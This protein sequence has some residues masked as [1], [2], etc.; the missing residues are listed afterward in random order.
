MT[1]KKISQTWLVKFLTFVHVN[2][3]EKKKNESEEEENE[4]LN[5]KEDRE[6]WSLY[7]QHDESSSFCNSCKANFDVLHRKHH[8][9][10]CGYI[11][12][13]Q[14]ISICVWV[15][16]FVLGLN[17]SA[18][19]IEGN[20]VCNLCFSQYLKINSVCNSALMVGN[21]K[22]KEKVY[23]IE[24]SADS[25]VKDDEISSELRDFVSFPK[26]FEVVQEYLLD[27]KVKNFCLERD[28]YAKSGEKNSKF[29]DILQKSDIAMKESASIYEKA[30]HMDLSNRLNQIF[31]G[32]N[33][34][35]NA[36][37]S[38][39]W[40]EILFSLLKRITENFSSRYV[41]FS[42]DVM[43]LIKV[44]CVSGG[45]PDS[46]YLLNGVMF[47][48][49]ICRKVNQSNLKNGRILLVCSPIDYLE[50]LSSQSNV[51]NWNDSVV[52][53]SVMHTERR[54]FLLSLAKKIISLNPS[55]VISS[56]Y[57]CGDIQEVLAKHNIICIQNLKDSNFERISRITGSKVF[58]V[59][60]ILHHV[61]A[62]S[63]LNT[64]LG[65]FKSFQISKVSLLNDSTHTSHVKI[66]MDLEKNRIFPVY[67]IC[68][69]GEKKPELKAIKKI[70][71][72]AFRN[73]VNSFF[74][75]SLMKDKFAYIS[76]KEDLNQYNLNALLVQSSISYVWTRIQKNL[77]KFECFSSRLLCTGPYSSQ[78]SSLGKFL[79]HRF[80][81][82]AKQ[83]WSCRVCRE[84][85]L[86]HLFVC[87]HGKG[88]IYIEMQ[89]LPFQM[90]ENDRSI[91]MW[92]RCNICGE[93]TTPITKMSEFTFNI[94]LSK[95]IQLV[96]EFSDIQ[97]LILSTKCMHCAFSQQTQYFCS[98]NF[99]V[100]FRFEEIN[101]YALES[102]NAKSA[103]IL[104]TC[105]EDFVKFKEISDEFL[106]LFSNKIS[107]ITSNNHSDLNDLD[108]EIQDSNEF[109]PALNQIQVYRAFRDKIARLIASFEAQSITPD[110]ESFPSICEKL[111]EFLC[112]VNNFH[113]FSSYSWDVPN[114]YETLKT[115]PI[116][117]SSPSSFL[118]HVLSTEEYIRFLYS[119]SFSEVVK[120]YISLEELFSGNS[121]DETL[122]NDSL[123][124]LGSS[125]DDHFQYDFKNSA[126]PFLKKSA[127]KV[128]FARQFHVLRSLYC[129]SNF[130][131][132]NSIWNSQDWKTTGGKSN[133][134]FRKT[135]DEKFV[136]KFISERE[137]SMFKE[138]AP[139]YFRHMISSKLDG[140]SS[141]LIP[142]LGMF[143]YV[144]SEQI[145]NADFTANPCV[146][147]VVMPNLFAG[148]NLNQVF[149]LKGKKTGRF[150]LPNS[151]SDSSSVLLDK[152]FIFYSKGM[153]LP[154]K[155]KSR[156]WLKEALERD[157]EFLSA[158]DIMDYSLLVG[159]KDQAEK[160]I[161]IGIIDYLHK[162]TLDKKLENQFKSMF[163]KEDPTVVHP[164]K[165]RK[166]FLDAMKAYFLF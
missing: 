138:T 80:F 68:L 37:N 8:C 161:L 166:R 4:E 90:I 57:I 98:Q 75:L 19:I 85:I 50:S 16:I 164:E 54:D 83:G 82:P 33:A 23:Y 29:K 153:P 100:S 111:K 116:N 35:E 159:I 66:E 70:F 27:E 81:R 144:P 97:R 36:R 17:C 9:R 22:E 158:C 127:I 121:K 67:T 55:V 120:S 162:Y 49:S 91:F 99:L 30:I 25:K 84:G 62:I 93:K 140:F 163:Q 79:V 39:V 95:F 11:F 15:F 117:R 42:Y 126:D 112:I 32:Q 156:T 113:T 14:R 52:S 157:T 60:D 146:Y 105:D 165:Y 46:S 154:L 69:R 103:R 134:S 88:R 152:N 145:L 101:A 13:K 150:I 102:Y 92:S 114:S 34:S 43:K 21:E 63:C 135:A 160:K 115:I 94:S 41:D 137:C 31:D 142:I 65:V 28:S 125:P 109:L 78:D 40:T 53:L 58:S 7:W 5:K 10:A 38:H 74:E 118:A 24:N 96:S 149:D 64:M 123:A 61:S 148:E 122:I 59:H 110:F 86:D 141:V 151:D 136:I 3:G 139:L 76:L 89:S 133:A 106:K 132:I 128:Y 1:E 47:T 56:S 26:T 73:F 2:G 45:K 71:I 48:K 124:G 108:V 87:S 143:K 130:E 18:G 44:K 131:F 119:A 20:R 77:S 72:G 155:L 12:C 104:M 6:A 129:S 107:V 51:Q 147:F